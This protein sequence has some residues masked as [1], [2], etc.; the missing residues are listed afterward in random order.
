MGK[1]RIIPP[2]LSLWDLVASP[3]FVVA[4]LSLLW[5]GD[6]NSTLSTVLYVPMAVQEMVMAV[7]LIFKGFDAV[8]LDRRSAVSA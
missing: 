5:S 3:L 4:S 1:S 6:P 7:W 2:W 8:V